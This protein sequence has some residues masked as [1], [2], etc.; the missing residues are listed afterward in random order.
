M[1][2]FNGE[3]KEEKAARKQ[4]EVQA[5]LDQKNLAMLRKYGL[6]ELQNPTDIASIRNIM[7]ELS[8]TGLMEM[9]LTFGAGSDRDILKN[10]M[11]YQRA[12]IEQNFIIIRQ[13]DRITKLLSDQPER[14]KGS[15]DLTSPTSFYFIRVCIHT[16]C[17][18]ICASAVHPTTYSE[19]C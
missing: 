6:E 11:Y 13:L 2:L 15:S 19:A 1:G 17:I 10:Q 3:S 12:M 8:G 14:Q 7:T 18:Y 9:G 5:R 16:L 4:A